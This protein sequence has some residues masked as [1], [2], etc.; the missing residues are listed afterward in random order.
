MKTQL[1]QFLCKA[2]RGLYGQDRSTVREELRS[3]IEQLMLEYQEEGDSEQVALARAISEFGNPKTISAGMAR[4]HSVPRL[5]PRIGMMAVLVALFTIPFGS[6]HASV[7]ATPWLD[8]QGT[9]FTFTIPVTELEAPLRRAGLRVKKV[10][11]GLTFELG[12]EWA[13]AS[14][15]HESVEVYDMLGA[16]CR[17]GFPV[18][19][20]TSSDQVVLLFGENR[21]ELNLPSS[22]TQAWRTQ[23]KTISNKLFTD[24]DDVY[25][26][27]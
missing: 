11:N 22:T 5:L 17:T 21:I 4:V 23:R 9:V 8:P 3:N 12:D 19:F 18:G 6:H 7:L 16:L 25:T 2:T 13:F 20:D 1:E 26:K 27:I 24:C 10:Q 14:R 15:F